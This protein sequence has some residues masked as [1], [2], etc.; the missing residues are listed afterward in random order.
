MRNKS[1]HSDHK[2]QKSAQKPSIMPAIN[3]KRS[4]VSKLWNEDVTMVNHM[5]RVRV[6]EMNMASFEFSH[7]D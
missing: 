2:C 6:G 4:S 1:K 3:T 7:A 5:A